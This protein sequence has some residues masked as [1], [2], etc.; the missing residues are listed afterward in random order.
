MDLESDLNNGRYQG[1]SKLDW[2]RFREMFE[3]EYAVLR[4][5]RP[6]EK[7]KAVFDVFEE[8]MKPAKLGGAD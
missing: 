7:F 1:A 6:Q 8:T 5:T 3:G 2:G 4:R